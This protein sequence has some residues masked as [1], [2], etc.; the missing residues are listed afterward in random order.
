MCKMVTAGTYF[1]IFEK[2]WF[3]GHW[4]DKMTKN[5]PE[6]TKD[7]IPSHV[8]SQEQYSVRSWFLIHLCKMISPG[9]FL[10]FSKLLLGGKRAKNGPNDNKLCLL[11]S[12]FQE[13]YI[14]WSLFMVHIWKMLISPGIFSVFQNLIFWVIKR[15]KRAKYGPKWQIILSV[16]VHIWGTINHM[17]VIYDTHV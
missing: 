7:Y 9:V 8:I 1:F 3:S 17:I 4:A 13:A 2:L 5:G 6:W 12:I 14:I 16:A 11:S 15:V 10:F